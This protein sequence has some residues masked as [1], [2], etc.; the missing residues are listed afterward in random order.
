MHAF[1]NMNKTIKDDLAVTIK[2]DSKLSIATVCFSIYAYQTLKKQ[3]ETIEELRF[4]LTSPAFVTEKA[5][6]EKREFYKPD[7]T[8]ID[9]IFGCLLDWGLPLSM[10][11]SRV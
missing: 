6:K 9:L 5:P 2:K 4:I 11:I 1:D 3:L 10:L 7:R 8:D